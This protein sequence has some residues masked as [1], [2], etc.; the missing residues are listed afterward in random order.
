MFSPVAELHPHIDERTQF[1]G[2]LGLRRRGVGFPRV[3]HLGVGVRLAAATRLVVARWRS[4]SFVL[5]ASA[6]TGVANTADT[7]ETENGIALLLT[8][9]EVL[10][11]S[12][13]Q[14]L[15]NLNGG[16]QAAG[17]RRLK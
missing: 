7:G 12:N 1:L 9:T 11:A 3:W 13:R 14:E 16:H 10:N 17:K 8:R 6:T 5:R 15:R 4:R 2:R